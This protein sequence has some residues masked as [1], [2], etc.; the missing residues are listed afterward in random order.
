MNISDEISDK[1]AETMAIIEAILFACGDPITVDKI[2]EAANIDTDT[3]AKLIS[4]LERK[5]NVSESG[6]RIIRLNNGFQ[7]TT[8]QEFAPY[9]KTALQNKRQ[10]PLTQAA[11][12][13]LAIVAYNQPVT[14]A[15]VEQV[16]GID[17]GSVVNNLVERGLLEEAGRLELPGRPV[18]YRTSDVFLR[19]FGLSSLSELPDLPDHDGQLSFDDLDVN[20]INEED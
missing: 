1:L 10:A 14:K 6:L 5:Y 4:R 3:A 18:S 12:E 7:I 20:Q 16:R 15:F 8:R 9:V 19:C 13:T 17:S 2:A 11:M